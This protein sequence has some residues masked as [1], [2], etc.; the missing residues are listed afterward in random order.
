MAKLNQDICL[1]FSTNWEVTNEGKA[2]T[3][4]FCHLPFAVGTLQCEQLYLMESG[5]FFIFV[6]AWPDQR[7]F[8]PFAVNI[9]GQSLPISFCKF[10]A[11]EIKDNYIYGHGLICRLHERH[12]HYYLIRSQSLVDTKR[13]DVKSIRCYDSRVHISVVHQVANHLQII[14][15]YQHKSFWLTA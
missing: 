3:W 10:I 1:L 12:E 14:T 13:H 5:E 9:F 7:Q 4:N 15:N 8:L 11:R 6:L 2:Q